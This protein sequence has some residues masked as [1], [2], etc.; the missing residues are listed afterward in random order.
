MLQTYDS[1]VGQT[2]K[3]KDN[4]L[5]E[6]SQVALEKL[7]KYLQEIK[8]SASLIKAD[9][10][11]KTIQSIMHVD[12]ENSK[13]VRHFIGEEESNL[14]ISN[15]SANAVHAQFRPN[16]TSVV[17]KLSSTKFKADKK[18]YLAEYVYESKNLSK[19]KQLGIINGLK[20]W[21]NTGDFTDKN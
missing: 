17:I 16:E 4:F 7:D 2:D 9:E 14:R 18:S 20:D 6:E 1:Y 19:E 12:E 21:I 11:L 3:Y 8:T 10:F 13:T 15:H 5:G